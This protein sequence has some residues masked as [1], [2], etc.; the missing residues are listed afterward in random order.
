MPRY[1]SSITLYNIINH[2]IY[3]I[4]Y[5]YYSKVLQYDSIF[6]GV[7][8]DL[9]IVR[10]A[11]NGVFSLVLADQNRFEN[12]D[13]RIWWQRPY[14]PWLITS[15]K[16][17]SG[18][19]RFLSS[20]PD[21]P[22][23]AFQAEIVFKI[24]ARI[25]GT[26]TQ[27]CRRIWRRHIRHIRADMMILGFWQRIWRFADMRN[28]SGYDDTDRMIQRIWWIPAHRMAD[29]TD[30]KIIMLEMWRL[31]CSNKWNLYPRNG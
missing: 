27:G 5:N 31:L 17:L 28:R 29:M 25:R 11:R 30:V 7:N 12:T 1:S 8:M 22:K 21:E 24:G 26:S 15:S 10:D 14:S 20:C 16:I 6:Q 2:Y 18:V 3:C 23:S 9:K 13:S 4:L 19:S